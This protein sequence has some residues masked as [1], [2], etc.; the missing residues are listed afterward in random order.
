MEHWL[1]RRR[2]EIE[3]KYDFRYSVLPLAFAKLIRDGRISEGELNGLGEDK[4]EVT[5][6]AA[7][8]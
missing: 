2:H 1:M 4:L 3:S 5:R 7:S 8:L 6:L